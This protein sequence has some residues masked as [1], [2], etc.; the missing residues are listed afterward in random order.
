MLHSCHGIRFL[1]SGNLFLCNRFAV[2]ES[3]VFVLIFSLV[4][5]LNAS[6]LPKVGRLEKILLLSQSSR[7]LRKQSIKE[8][9]S[10]SGS[11]L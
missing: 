2:T 4:G 8:N 10:F 7:H 5:N 6:P 11:N 1:Y 3:E 9:C